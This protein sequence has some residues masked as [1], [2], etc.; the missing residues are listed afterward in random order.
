MALTNILLLSQIAGYFIA[1]ILSLCIV[2]PMAWHQEDFKGHC[3][4]FSTGDWQETDGQLLVHWAS[5]SYCNYTI[6]VGVFLLLVSV[7]QIYRLSVFLYKGIDSSFFSAFVD[8]L[9]G[10]WLGGMTIIAAL[11]ITL[12]FMAWCQNMTERFPSC[13]LAAGQDI[14]HADKIN[15]A[16]FYI[17]MGTAQFGVWGS[18]A[19]WVGLSVCA[20]LK[21]CRYHQLENIRVSMYRERQRLI[22]ENADSPGS[23]LGRE[24]TNT[25]TTATA[26]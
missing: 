6:F 12:G 17:Q 21:L 8:V 10:I 20:L 13:E 16:N 22:N 15:T 26:E 25:Q 7:I 9:M 11:M 23:S 4:L 3:L 18:F 2:V 14:D 19:T 1:F 24:S 5:Q